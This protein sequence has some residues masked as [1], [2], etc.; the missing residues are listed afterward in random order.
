MPDLYAMQPQQRIL[1]HDRSLPLRWFEA[2]TLD[3]HVLEALRK[4][5]HQEIIPYSGGCMPM[6]VMPSYLP[7]CRYCGTRQP[8]TAIRCESCG[9]T[10]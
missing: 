2:N 10:Q 8:L 7:R 9:A 3:E 4:G 5:H 1:K 6:G